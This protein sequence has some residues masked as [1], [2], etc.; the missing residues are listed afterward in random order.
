MK[1]QSLP[2]DQDL[3]GELRGLSGSKG[4]FGMDATVKNSEDLERRICEKISNYRD[5][6][7]ACRNWFRIHGGGLLSS[8]T[9]INRGV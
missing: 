8:M 7:S 1:R 5:K 9:C 2:I 3:T 4:I 6:D